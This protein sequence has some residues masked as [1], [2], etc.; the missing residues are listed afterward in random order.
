MPI[1]QTTFLGA[2][3][4]SF[5]ANIGWNE[6]TTSLTIIVG[7]DDKNGDSFAPVGHGQPVHFE[8]DTFTFDGILQSWEKKTSISGGI[9]YE[10]V[11]N[12]PT[13]ILSSCELIIGNYNGSVGAIDNL[14]NIY[15]YYESLSFGSSMVNESGMPWTTL[16]A[17][18][19]SLTSGVANSWS[20]GYLRFNGHQYT[21]DL[22][23]LPVLPAY[24]R[25]GGTSINLLELI[26]RS[27]QDGGYDFIVELFIDGSDNII[28]IRTI[29]RQTQP[30][31]D[32]VYNFIESRTDVH[33]KTY[34]QELRNEVMSAFVVGGQ[35]ERLYPVSGVLDVNPNL[36]TI[37][38][39][40]GLDSN[41]NVI[42]GDGFNDE[43]TFTLDSRAVN[44]LG[45]GATYE[46]TVGELRSV[47]GN[48]DSWQT[49]VSSVFPTKASGI[50]IPQQLADPTIIQQVFET[51]GS[52]LDIICTKPDTVNYYWDEEIQE[53]LHNLYSFLK[54]IA[55]EYYGK[56]FIVR[57]PFVTYALET[58][59]NR[60]IGTYEPT[61]AGYLDQADWLLGN[62]PFSIPDIYKDI[63]TTE[64]GRWYC[65]VKVA[66]ASNY[67]LKD[68]PPDSIVV[69][70]NVAYLKC[71]VEPYMVFGDASLYT[72]PRVI[73]NLPGPINYLNDE[74]SGLTGQEQ[75]LIAAIYGITGAGNPQNLTSIDPSH[76]TQLEEIIGKNNGLAGSFVYDMGPS[77]VMPDAAVVPLRSNIETYGPWYSI[78]PQ[79]K[80]RFEQR[81][82][83][84]PWNYNG[85]TYLDFAG[86]AQ[87]SDVITAQQ[88]GEMGNITLAGSP[89][90]GIGDVLISGGPSVTSLSCEIG[91]GGITTSYTMRTYTPT[92]GTL[93]K[94]NADRFQ[95][96]ARFSQENE[97]KIIGNVRTN[98]ILNTSFTSA[99][100]RALITDT[101]PRG[102]KTESPHTILVS[103]YYQTSAN[104][105]I[106]GVNGLSTCTNYEALRSITDTSYDNLAICSLDAIFRPFSTK[107]IDFYT[108]KVSGDAKIAHI[109]NPQITT[110]E[111]KKTNES[112]LGVN[113]FSGIEDN[114]LADFTIGA[115]NSSLPPSG[116]QSYL[117]KEETEVRIIGLKGPLFVTGWGYDLFGKPVPNASTGNRT[118]PDLFDNT[119]ESG[120]RNKPEHWRAGPLDMRWNDITKMWDTPSRTMR[121]IYLGSVGGTGLFE[122]YH[123]DVTTTK[124]L[125][126]GSWL[127]TSA[128]TSGTKAI[129]GFVD[130]ELLIFAAD[131][132]E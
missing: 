86:N 2:S 1:E 25:I 48:M 4:S 64:D 102:I 60:L 74:N 106:I 18:L 35:Q 111:D 116:F 39:Y 68:I 76:I 13:D 54:D 63:F 131:C 15:G 107:K 61:D 32:L 110:T 77:A 120:F 128:M 67:D 21:L 126:L 84:V 6:Q 82:D 24:Y 104:T 58:D 95:R 14:I 46:C 37:W 50:G 70:S 109:E 100:E 127:N 27:C 49:Y 112:F 98:A 122:L 30:A 90:V 125:P 103:N 69:I 7:E 3:I 26:S 81:P 71:S 83:L 101:G 132:E 115:F 33:D 38:P 17:G 56:K 80:V 65:I 47:I 42:V 57:V 87:V 36:N 91:V 129:A 124:I 16:K 93:A 94:Y 43:H 44:C 20:T 8:F 53:G 34:G 28:R 92:F 19:I 5:S 23:Q 10:V 29:S 88:T 62:S 51:G 118:L 72:N 130:D 66:N 108:T 121:G 75:L 31:T 96:L 113:Y 114:G 52:L 123:R 73:I 40:W 9:Y 41:G 85:Y 45:V 105:G 22:S 99:R 97:R 59:T 11:V 89:I 78:G 79:G 55:D 12:S 117:N 119:F